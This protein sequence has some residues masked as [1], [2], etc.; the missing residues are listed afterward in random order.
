MPS[1]NRI[2][3]SFTLSPIL[4]QLKH[5]AERHTEWSCFAGFVFNDSIV[6]IV[7]IEEI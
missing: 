1:P 7:T 2:A 3:N 4:A 6:T 5:N